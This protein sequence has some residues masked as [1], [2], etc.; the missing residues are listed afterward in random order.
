M[1]FTLIF[2]ADPQKI[3][4]YLSE[5]SRTFSTKQA[6]EFGRSLK[7]SKRKIDTI[8]R[9]TGA[10]RGMDLVLQIFEHINRNN[11]HL[12]GSL[13]DDIQESLFTAAKT[14]TNE[15]EETL[16]H[17]KGFHDRAGTEEIIIIMNTRPI[18]RM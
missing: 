12:K 2:C 15:R 8:S 3:T 6:Y 7:L 4:D 11:T 10:K 17:H 5:V 14:M 18:Y 16:K 13:V 1:N 9:N